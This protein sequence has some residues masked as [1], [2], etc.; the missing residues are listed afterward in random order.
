LKRGIL[1]EGLPE[2]RAKNAAVPLVIVA[3]VSVRVQS[4]TTGI[5]Y[6]SFV[7]DLLCSLDFS[8]V[9][10]SIANVETKLA[11]RIR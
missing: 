8:I 9:V 1:Q 2:S 3:D 6:T 11:E 7:L 10:V 5:E 4:S